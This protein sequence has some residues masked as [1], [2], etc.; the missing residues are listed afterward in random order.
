VRIDVEGVAF[1][2]SSDETLHDVSFQARAGEVVGI[3]GHNGCG[4]TTM[5]RCINRALIPNK[6]SV[7]LD[8]KDTVDM[9]RKEIASE[10]GVVA[11]STVITFPFTVLD[12]VLMGRFP[13]LERLQRESGKDLEIAMR[14]MRATSIDDLAARPIDE[15]SGGERQRVIISRALAQEPRALLLDEPTLHLDINHQL[16]LMELVRKLAREQQMLVVFVTHDLNL[17]ARYC[18]R[19]LLMK[20]GRIVAA[21]EIERVL[22]PENMAEVFSIAAEVS[23]DN[24]VKAFTVAILHT[25]P[26]TKA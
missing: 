3:I 16:E 26:Q 18:D 25:L 11:Q 13:A 6:G 8:G 10:I 7:F 9:S 2:Y 19:L 24:R 21:G 17:A 5:L 20:K 14:C 15:L 12:M 4:K 22:T 1:S 23:Y